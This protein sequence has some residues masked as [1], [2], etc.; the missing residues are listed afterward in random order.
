MHSKYTKTRPQNQLIS[1]G[2][3]VSIVL[4]ALSLFP[5]SVAVYQFIEPV[6]TAL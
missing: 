6:A 2:Q 5:D 1:H 4:I 3:C